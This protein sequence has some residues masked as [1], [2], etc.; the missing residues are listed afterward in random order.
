MAE[1]VY[2][3]WWESIAA[4]QPDA[5][6]LIHGER[7]VS[8]GG[9]DAAADALARA[10][11]EAGLE[12]QAKVAVYMHNSPEF[13]TAY[14][15]AFKA[16]LVPFNVN[17][18]Y[19][20]EELAYLL[21]NADAEAVVFDAEFAPKLDVIRERMSGVK[22]WI[23][24]ARPG[25]TVPEW[26]DCGNDIAARSEARGVKA[27]WGR[28][29]DDLMLIY[30]GGTTGMPKGVMWRQ[31][32]LIGATG[33][34]AVPL[35][36]LPPLESPADAGA[37][38]LT[39]GRPVSLIASPMMHATGLMAAFGALNA[40]GAAA[41]L[42]SRRFDAV[43]LWSEVER[44]RIARLS[45]VG[46]AFAQPMLEALDANP[47]RWDLTCVRLIGSS[48]SMWSTEN[49]QGLLRHLPGATLVD[50]FASSEAFGMGGSQ[51]T[52]GGEAQTARF[53]VGVNCAVFTE[54][55]RR[56]EPG[57]GERGM[58]AVGGHIPLGYYKDPEKSARTFPTYEGR[59]WSIPGDWATVDG[60]GN[61]TL[62]GRG[63]QCINSG[64]E[65]VFPEEVEEALKRHPAV[66]DAAVVGLPD[67]RFGE[68]IAALVELSPG[69]DDPG[70][71]GLRAYVRAQ[72]ADYKAPRDVAL[73]DTVGRAPNG[74]LDYK[75]VKARALE[76]FAPVPA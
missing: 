60:E 39:G 29:G 22:L 4:V 18:R 66:R 76:H 15:A 35:L 44:L 27:P 62:L 24:V 38:A 72:L 75:A 61:L 33:F 12:R 58:T 74:K 31:A 71:D 41:V 49:K 70:S 52:A 17:Y 14:A 7:V 68:R 9:L 28:S 46:L 63:S 21:D 51:S 64:G 5:P 1:W 36:G 10:L 20:P 67:A 25:E 23:A 69:H 26:A 43:E 11:L 37:R 3:D 16:G 73:V 48:G 32:D 50:A 30:T 34:G 54:D 53:T 2:A 56:V 6:A 13:V 57:S 45:I 42:P 59:R 19:G 47:G 65:K 40:G 55:G 8:W